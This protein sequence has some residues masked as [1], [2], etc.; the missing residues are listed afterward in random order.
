MSKNI[1]SALF[2]HNFEITRST[3]FGG[4]CAEMINNRKFAAH[5]DGIPCGFEL[6][7]CEGRR[8][9]IYGNSLYLEAGVK[10]NI[11]IRA[12]SD[13][14]TVFRYRVK[15]RYFKVFAEGTLNFPA[16][17]A[18][19]VEDDFT[20]YFTETKAVFEITYPDTA[21][22]EILSLSLMRA[23][24]FFGMRRDVLDCLREL[25]PSIL[26]YPGGCYAEFYNWK[27]GL[28]EPDLRPCINDGGLSFLL[29]DTY[30]IDTHEIG[31]DEF[32]KAC[33]Y[34]GA[35][36]A[37]TIRLSDNDPCDAADWV[38][39]CNGSPDT[40]WG[41]VRTARGYPEPYNVRIWYIG[42][43]IFAFGRGKLHESGSYTAHIHNEFCTAMKACDPNILTVASAW[44]RTEWSAEFLRLAVCDMVSF[45]NYANDHLGDITDD[46]SLSRA[47]SAPYEFLLPFMR[48]TTVEYGHKP[49]AFDEWNYQWAKF[50]SAMTGI[51]TAGV[52]NMLITH[53]D[54][55]NLY[56]A[57]Y[58]TPLGES[59]VRIFSDHAVLGPDG[60]IFRIFTCHIGQEIIYQNSED[61]LDLLISASSDGNRTVITYVNRNIKKIIPLVLPGIHGKIITS[62]LLIPK[63]GLITD[64]DFIE[65]NYVGIPDIVP[66]MSAGMA[67]L[68]SN[69]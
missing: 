58:F 9:L 7:A 54:E 53:A 44:P 11:R 15:S 46:E 55:L 14:N 62:V 36:P 3:A 60:K 23:D 19:T 64:D 61:K 34:V 18:I 40:K 26:R 17:T 69:S 39:Y 27:D 66:P 28:L 57:C 63:N 20:L 41:A 35:E 30:G 56:Q 22:V 5:R 33:R 65:V 16:S 12:R 38:E 47:L 4:I 59:A 25:N 37:I 52:L 24:N 48:E 50:G 13:V 42:N 10:Y 8:G 1:S 68:K 6:I 21:G 31:I 2:G 67:I 43:E 32:I 45:H 29:P 49:I 51:Y